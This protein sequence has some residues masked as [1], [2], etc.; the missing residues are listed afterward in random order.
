MWAFLL[1]LI[2]FANWAVSSRFLLRRAAYFSLR[3]EFPIW[4]FACLG[5]PSRDPRPFEMRSLELAPFD[6]FLLVLKALS[7]IP[8]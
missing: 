3:S 6:C 7:P 1:F 2:V 8:A 5:V 4:G